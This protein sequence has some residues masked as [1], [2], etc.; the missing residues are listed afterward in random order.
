MKSGKYGQLRIDDY[1]LIE[2]GELGDAQI[3]MERVKC[4]D[5]V[6]HVKIA[7]APSRR[8]DCHTLALKLTLLNDEFAVSPQVFPDRYVSHVMP[9]DDYAGLPSFFD[10]FKQV[11]A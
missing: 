6:R 5:I 8:D 7:P 4:L 1:A 3:R 11:P 9:I 2:Y 10:G